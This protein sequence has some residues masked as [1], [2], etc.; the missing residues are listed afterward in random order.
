TNQ[1]ISLNFAPAE[2]PPATYQRVV[3]S[4]RS[5]YGGLADLHQLVTGI[6]AGRVERDDA[7]AQLAA[8]RQRRK[9]FPQSVAFIANGVW[10][11]AFVMFIGGSWFSA[12]LSLGASTLSIATVYLIGR[13]RAPE[14]FSTM[15]GGI[16]AT[17]IAYGL[18]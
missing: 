15:A 3:R 14:V 17:V 6:A 5:D 2:A 1:S 18:Y 7:Q 4:W 11:S 16:M 8:I 9:T 12:L 13:L 10:A